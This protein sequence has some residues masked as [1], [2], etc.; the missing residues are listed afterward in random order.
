MFSSSIFCQFLEGGSIGCL[1]AWGSSSTFVL[2]VFWE[3]DVIYLFTVFK[4]FIIHLFT[5]SIYLPKTC[6]RK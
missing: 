2:M 1:Q 5:V 6:K 4:W 3:Y